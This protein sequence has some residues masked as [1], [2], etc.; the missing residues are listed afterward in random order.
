MFYF[1]TPW[2]HQ[3]TSGCIKININGNIYFHIFL[4]RLKRFYKGLKFLFFDP[5]WD[6]SVKCEAKEI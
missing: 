2:K 6:R 3:K 1:H 4:R 5:D